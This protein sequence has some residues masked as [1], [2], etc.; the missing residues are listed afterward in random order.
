MNE[1]HY[2]VTP[3]I[4]LSHYV[5]WSD[6]S[7]VDDPT[8]RRS[9]RSPIMTGGRSILTNV[10]YIQMMA[11]VYL[12]VAVL[13]AIAAFRRRPMSDG[14]RVV[15]AA[16][17]GVSCVAQ[18]KGID[19]LTYP[20][21]RWAMY[22]EPAARESYVDV[23]I[24]TS[25]HSKRRYPYQLVVF[26]SPWSFEARIESLIRECRCKAADHRVDSVLEALARIYESRMDQPVIEVVVEEVV[27]PPVES[28]RLL[29]LWS[30]EARSR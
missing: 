20:F 23:L 2:T 22:S 5:P 15:A 18:I 14:V 10:H 19:T 16:I 12:G 7:P 25:G 26:G 24:S 28:R 27:P 4:I 6:P 21:V 29:Y 17:V 9:V 13:V 8:L 3:Y 1:T 11:A 30:R